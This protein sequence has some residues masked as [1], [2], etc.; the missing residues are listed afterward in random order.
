MKLIVGLGNPGRQYERTRHNLGFLVA[1]LLASRW[2]LSP[3]MKG[4]GAFGRGS[5]AGQPAALLK[6]M[7]FMNRSGQAVLEVVQFYKLSLPDLL[8]IFDDLD[9]PVGRV[10]MRVN[11]SAGG[12]KGLGD[13]IQRLGSDEIARI[14]IGIGRPAGGDA[15]DYVL[16]PPRPDEQPPIELALLRAAEASECWLTEGPDAAMNRYNRNQDSQSEPE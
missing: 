8:V 6:P 9:L 1:D 14:R 2:S 10:R 4:S 12:H 16:S 3:A 15:V 7:T 11:G 13:I 5:I